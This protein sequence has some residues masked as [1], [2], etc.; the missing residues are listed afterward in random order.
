MVAAHADE[1]GTGNMPTMIQA[2]VYASVLHY[3]KA[4]EEAGT[5]DAEAVMAAMKE[6]PTDDPLFGQGEIG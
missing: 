3:L 1:L 4:V 2:G 5:K 6:M